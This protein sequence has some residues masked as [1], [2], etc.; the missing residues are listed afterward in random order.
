MGGEQVGESGKIGGE[1]SGGG[2][3]GGGVGGAD[4]R[5]KRSQPGATLSGN[6]GGSNED[7]GDYL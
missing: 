2:C 6:W 3:Y 7:L 1:V 5:Q 4:L